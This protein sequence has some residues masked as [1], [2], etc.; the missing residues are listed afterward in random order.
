[1]GKLQT[2]SFACSL[3]LIYGPGSVTA[4]TSHLHCDRGVRIPPVSTKYAPIITNG[5]GSHPLK[6]E[7]RVRL[8]LGV[9]S[10]WVRDATGRHATLRT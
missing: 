2:C 4:S 3:D 9:L 1:M 5:S 10:I 7:I 6:V 8:P